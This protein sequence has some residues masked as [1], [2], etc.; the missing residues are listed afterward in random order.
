[1]AK[2]FLV[3]FI[4]MNSLTINSQNIVGKTFEGQLKSTCVETTEDMYMI[5]FYRRFIFKKDTVAILDFELGTEA[6]FH[7]EAKT[8][9]WRMINGSISINNYAIYQ[10]I[11]I[12]ESKII[13]LD[14]NGNE[15]TFNEV[16]NPMQ[17]K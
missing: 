3:L 17:P 10:K 4:I 8:Y 16:M 1:M 12:R 13:C 9:T 2:L 5:H 6:S 11:M 14:R 7:Q 15:F